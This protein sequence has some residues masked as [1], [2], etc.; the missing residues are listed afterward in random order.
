MSITLDN[1]LSALPYTV[2][3]LVKRIIGTDIL[4]SPNIFLVEL[5]VKQLMTIQHNIALEIT[6]V[7]EAGLL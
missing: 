7:V 2:F 4:C 5:E 1:D 6:F 3:N